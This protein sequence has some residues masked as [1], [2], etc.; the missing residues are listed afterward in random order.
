MCLP[1]IF[2]NKIISAYMHDKFITPLF[3]QKYDSHLQKNSLFH[4]ANMCS[5][6]TVRTQLKTVKLNYSFLL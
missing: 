1:Q 5:E 2:Y 3:S 4:T 6:I